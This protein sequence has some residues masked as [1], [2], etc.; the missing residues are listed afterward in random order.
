MVS[1]AILMNILLFLGGAVV[2][3][4]WNPVAGAA[5]RGLFIT[6]FRV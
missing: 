2:M 6:L 4:M 1:F 3:D 5:L